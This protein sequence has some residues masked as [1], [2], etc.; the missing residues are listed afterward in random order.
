MA[1]W[2]VY[3]ETELGRLEAPDRR[4]AETMAA[5]WYGPKVTRVQ[6]V[7]SLEIQHPIRVT[8]TKRRRNKA[9]K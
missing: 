7:A 6:S 3:G 1:R 8:A 9:R 5:E 4:R 2:A